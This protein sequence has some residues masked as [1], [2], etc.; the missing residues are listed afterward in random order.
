MQQ[1]TSAGGISMEGALLAA[2]RGWGGLASAQQGMV[3][4]RLLTPLKSCLLLPA[5]EL[6]PDKV[7]SHTMY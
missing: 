4:L 5:W 2:Q 7:L 6:V 1:G 3:A